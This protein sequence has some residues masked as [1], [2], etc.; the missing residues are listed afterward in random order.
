MGR[1]LGTDVASELLARRPELLDTDLASMGAIVSAAC[2]SHDMGNPP[3]GHS[4][5][6]AI[7]SF[8]A[9]GRGQ[10]LRDYVTPEGDQLTDAEWSDL[11][12]FDGNANTF[13]LLTH[14]F[15]GR[16][17]GGFVMTYSTLST[18]C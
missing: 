2:L 17:R 11:V 15:G 8:F 13:R 10:R 5:E 16:R 18:R 3:F 12:N 4:G 7:R 1:S 9:E 6:R 14:Q